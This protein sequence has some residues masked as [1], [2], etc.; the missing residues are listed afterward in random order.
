MGGE[1]NLGSS[2]G[3]NGTE[4][5]L[6]DKKFDD[7]IIKGDYYTLFKGQ[8]I[9]NNVYEVCAMKKSDAYRKQQERLKAEEKMKDDIKSIPNFF[10]DLF[11]G[12]L[13]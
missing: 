8:Q 3:S 4:F 5:A 11:L 12:G 7:T 1:N 2:T 6:S 9:D 13:M 10:K